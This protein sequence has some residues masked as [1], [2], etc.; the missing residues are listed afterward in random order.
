MKKIKLILSTTLLLLTNTIILAQEVIEVE[1]T[2]IESTESS[3]SPNQ[4]R[5]VKNIYKKGEHFLTGNIENELYI[6]KNNATDLY[7]LQDY[8]GNLLVRPMFKN[9]D[10]YGSTK[11]RII[12][13]LEYS[14]KGVI[15]K[16]G[17][18]IIPLQYSSITSQNNKEIY[19]VGTS[20]SNYS[21]VDNNGKPILDG[22][23]ERISV[24]D[25]VLKV[26]RNDAYGVFNLKGEKLLPLEYD[27][28]DYNTSSKF[29]S[30][31]KNGVNSVLKRNGERLFNKK[32]TEV[33]NYG[34]YKYTEF[35]VE[36]NGE[37]GIISF[38]EKVIV[39][40]KF[41]EIDKSNSYQLYIVKQNNLWGVYDSYFDKF[42]IEATFNE[43]K[44]LS[45]TTYILI[46]NSKKEIRNV[47]FK[48]NIDVSKY[49]FPDYYLKNSNYLTTQ[50]DNKF[51]LLNIK[52]GKETVPTKYDKVR[53]NYGFIS[54]YNNDDRKYTGY[55]IDGEVIAKDFNNSNYITSK[56]YKITK[57]G[58]AG[59][60]YD[61]KLAAKIDYDVITYYKDLKVIVLIK[62]NLYSLLD[63]ANDNMIIKDSKEKISVNP[64]TN[65]ITHNNKNYYYSSGQI[66]EE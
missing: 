65:K 36:K 21:I 17:E 56:L 2:V 40:L 1:E 26:K 32:Y 6:I 61:G 51:G 19:I 23:F 27:K 30:V 62:D 28:I 43:I 49:N 18:I 39:P 59:L 24:Y 35:L 5:N 41:Q 66:K 50:K 37:K 54:A 52:T 4:R 16:K 10:K 33:E 57:N 22:V 15:N 46:S 20:Y 47:E 31:T 34:G 44:R 55:N 7:G 12:V 53:V 45:R 38:D 29:F 63:Y 9:I 14:K 25:D 8:N 64:S 11:N 42:L 3:Y 13:T 58:K 48:T 60:I